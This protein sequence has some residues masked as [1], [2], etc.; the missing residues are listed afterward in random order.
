VCMGMDGPVELWI[1]VNENGSVR[2]EFLCTVS[3]C[4]FNSWGLHAVP[5]CIYRRFVD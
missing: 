5:S 2:V 4:V 3:T 1:C